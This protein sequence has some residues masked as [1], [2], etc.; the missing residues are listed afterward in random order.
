MQPRTPLDAFSLCGWR[1]LPFPITDLFSMGRKRQPK[2]VVVNERGERHN[3]LNNRNSSN[4][5]VVLKRD[6][7]CY[8]LCTSLVNNTLS[9]TI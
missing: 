8:T 4:Q 1:I 6:V 2:I 7:L 5:K 9:N 3:E